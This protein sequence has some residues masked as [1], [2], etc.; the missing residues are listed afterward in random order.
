M[1]QVPTSQHNNTQ[2]ALSTAE[3]QSAALASRELTLE[4]W[5]VLKEIVW[6]GAETDSAILMAYDYCKARNL[7]PFKR[8]IHIVS[9][10]SRRHGKMVETIWPGISEL[11]TTASRTGEYVGCGA[12]EWG[13]FSEKK[14]EWQEDVWENKRKITV[15]KSKTITFPE[16]CRITVKRRHKSGHISD[17]TAEVYWEEAY[18][19]V[20]RF[21]DAPNEMW[22]KR[23]RGQVAKCTEAA[24]I[25]MAFPEEVGNDLTAEEMEGQMIDISNGRMVGNEDKEKHEAPPAP[26]FAEFQEEKKPAAGDEPL[27]QV[28]EAEIIDPDG[29]PAQSWEGAE[30]YVEWAKAEIA[31]LDYPEAVQAWWNDQAENRALAGIQDTDQD[32]HASALEALCKRQTKNLST[33]VEPEFPGD[34]K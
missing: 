14:F 5:R 4:Q 17:Y 7:D 26:T 19:T 12:P 11:R 29:E 28:E 27:E 13:P 8:P 2:M 6:P 33:P 24:A 3:Q 15:T 20:N 25:R 31:K 34:R 1:G 21:S 32:P 16:Y 18:A 10:Y 23:P 30:E 9:M 22:R